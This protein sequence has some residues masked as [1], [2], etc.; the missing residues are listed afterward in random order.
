MGLFSSLAQGRSIPEQ[1]RELVLK[2]EPFMTRAE[3]AGSP[4]PLSLS[5]SLSLAFSHFTC[6]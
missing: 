3:D 2:N 5:Q 6:H 1:E 4:P